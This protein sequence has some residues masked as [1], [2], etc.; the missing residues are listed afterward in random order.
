MVYSGLSLYRVKF[1][2]E[3]SG[4]MVFLVQPLFSLRI[5]LDNLLSTATSKEIVNVI[6]CKM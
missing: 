5:G 2:L 1:R 3:M 6:S 4:E